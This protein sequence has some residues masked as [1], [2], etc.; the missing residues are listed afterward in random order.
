MFDDLEEDIA[1]E[2]SAH[3]PDMEWEH[4]VYGVFVKKRKRGFQLRCPCGRP[5]EFRYCSKACY[6]KANLAM[7]IARKHAAFVAARDAAKCGVCQAPMPH[8]RS[9]NRRYCSQ[10][11]RSRRYREK[12][13][14]S[15]EG[16]RLTKVCNSSPTTALNASAGSTDSL[17]PSP[18]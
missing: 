6:F 9:T 14:S 8:L 16:P 11:C 3:V 10:K 12:R 13:L 18:P 4:A 7:T 5:A 15:G 1:A 2:F 17:K